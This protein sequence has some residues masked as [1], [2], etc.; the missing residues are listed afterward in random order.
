VVSVP[1]FPL[2]AVLFEGG[3]MPLQI[4]EPRYLDMVSH[5]MRNGGPIGIVLIRKGSDART[6]KSWAQPEIFEIGTEAHV[7]D[8]NQL[9]NGN[10]GIIVQ[11]GRKFRVLETSSQPDHL[12]CGKVEYFLTEDPVGIT[13]EYHDLVDILE[14][15]IQHPGVQKLGVTVDLKSANS[16]SCILSELLPIEPE[17]KQKLLQMEGPMERLTE[18]NRIVNKLRG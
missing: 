4:F 2:R 7:V 8:F 10:L 15:L 14:E 13:S 18:L 12:L 5:A 3:R 6:N 9:T 17:V 16:V 1:L 11:G